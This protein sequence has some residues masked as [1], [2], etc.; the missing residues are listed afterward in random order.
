MLAVLAGCAAPQAAGVVSR[1]ADGVYMLPGAP[2]LAEP[3]NQGRIGNAGFV[4]GDAGVIVIDTGTSFAQGQALLAAIRSVTDKPVRL[5]LITHVQPEFLFGANAFRAAGVPIHMHTKASRLMA[6]RCET[7][8]KALAQQLGDDTMRGTG[9]FKPEHEFDR[10]HTID[11]AGRPVQVLYFGHSSGPGD[12]AVF[13]QRSRV[14]FGGGLVDQQRIPDIIDS[15]LAG[16]KVALAG[17][18]GLQAVTVVPGHGPASPPVVID[19]VERYLAQL[20]QGA[21]ALVQA[22]VSLMDVPDAVSL[23]EFKDWDLYDSVHRRNASI[24]F[25]RVERELLLK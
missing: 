23:P 1:L 17:L 7:C 9:T 24:V 21:R 5:A 2:G 20:E 6:S 14:L 10:T 19:T 15:D 25:L 22:G 8:L 16:W 13:D 3:A 11:V 4:V 12:V 18:R